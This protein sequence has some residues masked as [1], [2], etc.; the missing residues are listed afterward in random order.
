[1]VA[2]ISA[3]LRATAAL[4][5]A[6]ALILIVAPASRAATIA[7]GETQGCAISPAGGLSCWGARSS[8][9]LGDGLTTSFSYDPVPV[10]GLGAGVTDVAMSSGSGGGCGCVAA[11]AT[12]ARVS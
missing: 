4:I 9:A 3:V 2:Q 6:L 12:P 1:M 8:G 5:C 7:A 11:C 10:S